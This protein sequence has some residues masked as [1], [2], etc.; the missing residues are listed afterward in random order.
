MVNISKAELDLLK[1][2]LSSLFARRQKY[3]WIDSAGA[4]TTWYYSTIGTEMPDGQ[5]KAGKQQTMVPIFAYKP[6]IDDFIHRVEF[7]D[8]TV[9]EL[10]F[11]LIP[12]ISRKTVCINIAELLVLINKKLLDTLEVHED[13]ATIEKVVAKKDPVTTT[14]IYFTDKITMEFLIGQCDGI[15]NRV[16]D[17]EACVKV[18]ISDVSVIK[19]TEISFLT[20]FLNSP[21][22]PTKT[23]TLNFPVCDGCALVSVPEFSKKV[24]GDFE[25][26][27]HVAFNMLAL[28]VVPE[29]KNASVTV[30]SV[31]PFALWF[32]SFK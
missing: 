6:G 29:F 3:L 4:A 19:R 1:A 23:S 26:S 13:R 27:V 22:D 7:T 24:P 18:P 32:P 11:T 30:L 25:L 16:M 12:C 15:I 28:Q 20:I 2:Y 10:F 8:W 5:K 21:V 14:V 17:N 31:Q 9:P